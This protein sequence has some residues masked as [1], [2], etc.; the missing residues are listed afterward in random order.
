MSKKTKRKKRL[1]ALLPAGAIILGFLFVLSQ[2][3]PVELQGSARE[4]VVNIPREATAGQVGDILKQKDVIKSPFFFR[5]YARYRGL[6]GAIKAGEYRIPNSLSVPRV[7]SELVDGRLAVQTVTIPEGF[8]TEQV[9]DLLTEKGV[10]DRDRFISVLAGDSFGYS[11][12]DQIPSGSDRLE[13][14]LF[15][16]TYQF[17]RGSGERAIIDKMLGRFEK[18][19]VD[20]DYAE[21]AARVGLTVRQAVTVA[22]MIEREAKFDQERPLISGVIFNRLKLSM[23]LQ[24]DA[25]VQ[26]A[27]HNHKEKIYYR[28][29][30]VDSP[31]NTYRVN[32]LP[33]GPIAL[34]GRAS[35]LAAVNPA[36]S[37][38][39]YYVVKPDGTHAFASSL[40]EHDLNREKYQ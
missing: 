25:T 38:Y 19:M 16:D 7:L 31:Y 22:S 5:L 21:K 23:P 24:I 11:F 8:T 34:P 26:Y 36:N 28:D 14:Y 35:L 20:L 1:T 4:V 6:D 18:E 39:L 33:P 3:S 13:G 40:A 29:L 17:T 2:L 37:D 15:P 10:V 30:E 9:A 32:G 12:M 27:L